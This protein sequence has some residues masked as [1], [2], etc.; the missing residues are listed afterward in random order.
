M[1]HEMYGGPMPRHV[2]IERDP[3]LA[4]LLQPFAEV[5]DFLDSETQD[6]DPKTVMALSLWGNLVADFP[7]SAFYAI[8]KA[9]AGEAG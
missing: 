5:A 1:F 3:Q 6:V 7:V 4:A 2:V 9:L 8:R